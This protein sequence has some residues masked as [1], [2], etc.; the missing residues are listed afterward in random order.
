[1]R[2]EAQGLGHA[3]HTIELMFDPGRLGKSRDGSRHRTGAVD[4]WRHHPGR[5]VALALRLHRTD[6]EA[7]ST[8][9]SRTGR[10]QTTPTS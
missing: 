7:G 5:H 1:M 10:P 8:A 9:S 4:Y 6:S 2:A 3:T